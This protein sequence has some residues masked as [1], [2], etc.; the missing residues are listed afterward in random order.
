M[1]TRILRQRVDGSYTWTG[2]R[3]YRSDLILNPVIN[4]KPIT[5]RALQTLALYTTPVPDSSQV[6]GVKGKFGDN[7][8][9]LGEIA[10]KRRA[11][12]STGITE[13][14]FET[15]LGEIADTPVNIEGLTS[16]EE[17]FPLPSGFLEVGNEPIKDS[18]VVFGEPG[19]RILWAMGAK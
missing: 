19:R 16:G 17:I 1:A 5:R 3:Q 8:H 6:A 9:S 15:L 2:Q 11:P 14:N 12:P 4:G 18:F 10:P 7:V 13:L